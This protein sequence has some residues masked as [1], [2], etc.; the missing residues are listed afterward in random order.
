MNYGMHVILDNKNVLNVL[1]TN[2][3][4]L[5]IFLLIILKYT[6]FY[7]WVYY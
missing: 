1:F 7:A 4:F 5:N 3:N 2:D 6:D